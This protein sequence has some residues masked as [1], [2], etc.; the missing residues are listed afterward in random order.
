VPT[1]TATADVDAALDGFLEVC[2]ENDVAYVGGDTKAG[3]WN[4]VACGVGDIETAPGRRH[5][6]MPG[7]VIVICG[8]IGSFTGATL[9]AMNVAK[10]VTLSEAKAILCHPAA[11]WNEANVLRAVLIPS[12]ATDA[13]DGLYEALLNLPSAG[14]G[15]R[16]D[17][18]LLPFSAVGR[19]VSE[20]TCM[21]PRNLLYGGGDW[22]LVL[23]VPKDR[24]GV[25]TALP[26]TDRLQIAAVGE[27]ISEP[28]FMMVAEDGRYGRLEGIVSDHF[29]GKIED[30]VRYF[31]RLRS[32]SGWAD[33]S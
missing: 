32:Y 16:I 7:D 23:A 30:P 27:V 17:E 22:N 2:E 5:A 29:L 15:I 28:G 24:V 20:E 21:P 26:L 1:D 9:R 13:S 6:A 31:E 12:A 18:R 19:R 8:E 3:P 10:S 4:L 25:L 11:R 14:F 33:T